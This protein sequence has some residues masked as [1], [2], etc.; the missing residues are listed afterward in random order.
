MLKPQKKE[1]KHKQQIQESLSFFFFLMIRRPPRSTLFPYTTLFRSPFSNLNNFR[2]P[3]AHFVKSAKYAP[4]AGPVLF[5]KASLLEYFR[6]LFISGSGD[7]FPGNKLFDRQTH[8]QFSGIIELNS[9]I[10]N[11]DD[12][13]RTE[14][15][16]PVDNGIYDNFPKSFNG[17]FPNLM[18][19]WISGDNNIFIDMFFDEGKDPV[20]FGKQI[21][22]KAGAILDNGLCLEPSKLNC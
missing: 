22:L 10:K 13:I 16:V 21:S 18:V 14:R 9:I 8:G 19:L 3:G 5:N 12:R 7:I 17:V 15:I 11:L 6:N 4:D 20:H 1:P 2:P